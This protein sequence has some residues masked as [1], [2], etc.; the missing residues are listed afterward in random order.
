MEWLTA[1]PETSERTHYE[2]AIYL[3]LAPVLRATA[4]SASLETERAYSRARLL[5]QQGGDI[6]S[7]LTVLEGLC[8]SY[9]VRGQYHRVVE[10]GEELLALA[11][12]WPEAV[13]R[14][15]AHR[16]L[17]TAKINSKIDRSALRAARK[18]ASPRR[19][20]ST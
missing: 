14:L 19:A 8:S 16:A 18:T 13:H 17:G 10:L 15:E 6:R 4:G 2:S 9:G 11:Q 5:C 20:S 12:R 7:L 3:A 1:L